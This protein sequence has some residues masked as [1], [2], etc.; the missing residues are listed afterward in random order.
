MSAS[1]IMVIRHAEKPVDNLTGIQLDGSPDPESLIPQGWQRA[2]ALV[3]LFDSSGSPPNAALPVPQ[4]LFASS[5]TAEGGSKRPFET[6]QPLSLKL[7]LTVNLDYG[8]SDYSDMVNTAV[9]CDGVVLI[10]W[11]HEDI[12]NVGNAI[13]GNSTTVPQS[14]T[15]DRFDV[16][17][18]F[19]AQPSG[20]YAFTQVPQLVLAGDLSTPIPD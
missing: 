16:V 3:V 19:T 7:N 2:G 6:V 13:V 10:A 17:W 11:E 12:P 1:I 14:W 8:K 4:F 9:K 18:V 15:S 20:G 5:Y